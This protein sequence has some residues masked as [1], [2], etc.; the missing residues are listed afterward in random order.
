MKWFVICVAFATLILV[1]PSR[2]ERQHL[3]RHNYQIDQLPQSQR[4]STVKAPLNAP[5][6]MRR[7][8]HR[9]RP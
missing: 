8:P 7:T 4:P 6:K 3:N 9:L 1:T 2:A 5:R